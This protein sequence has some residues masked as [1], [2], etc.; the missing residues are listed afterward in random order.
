VPAALGPAVYSLE[1]TRNP[2]VVSGCDVHG[3]L[4]DPDETFKSAPQ[5][6]TTVVW[7]PTIPGTLFVRIVAA[8]GD[9]EVRCTRWW[10]V[11]AG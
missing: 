8:T 7:S 11:E 3:S 6:G 4:G 10:T 1:V 5:A 2:D 9:E